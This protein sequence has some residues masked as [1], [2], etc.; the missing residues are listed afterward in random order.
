M[1][2]NDSETITMNIAGLKLGGIVSRI[3]TRGDYRNHHPTLVNLG[4]EIT[5]YTS[6]YT[7]AIHAL[8]VYYEKYNNLDI[9][10][11]YV[12]PV[13]DLSWPVEFRGMKLGSQ[14]DHIRRKKRQLELELTSY[15]TSE[16]VKRHKRFFVLNELDIKTLNDMGFIW[17]KRNRLN[18]VDLLNILHTYKSI[19]GNINIPSNYVIPN[20]DPWPKSLYGWC[21]GSRIAH[22]RNRGD[23][24]EL[25]EDLD[26]LNFPWDVWRDKQFQNILEALADFKRNSLSESRFKDP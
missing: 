22:I 5:S 12:I 10:A 18:G 1:V 14:V 9:K 25:R 20:E 11:K 23:Y 26:F 15:K 8:K 13:E 21:L 4:L 16:E 7:K 19:H 6:H 3:R 2:P 24:H 17:N